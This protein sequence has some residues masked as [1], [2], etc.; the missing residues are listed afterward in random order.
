MPAGPHADVFAAIDLGTN[1]FHL[2]IARWAGDRFEELHRER[3]FVKVASDGIDTIGAAPIARAEAALSSIA[4]ALRQIPHR[5]AVAFA[6][7]ALRTAS[8]GPALRAAWSDVLGVPIEIIDGHRE[9]GLIAR[10][11]LV[12]GFPPEGRQLVMDIGGGSCEFILI[13]GGRVRF[14]ESYPVGAQVLRQRFHRAEPFGAEQHLV[15]RNYL[16]LTL[17][18][19]VAAAGARPLT[20]VGASGTFDVLAALYGRPLREAVSEVA[21]ADTHTLF[22]ESAALDEAARFADPRIPDDRADMIVVALALIE[23]V[24]DALNVKRLLTCG[25]ALKEGALLELAERVRG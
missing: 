1:T 17:Q 13:D 10:G 5:A 8:N 3:H 6:T 2:L 21:L 7:A 12:A 25:Y 4:T 24:V 14:S 22:V 11:V 20:L 15:L 18:P 9:A 19:V 23:F 16:A